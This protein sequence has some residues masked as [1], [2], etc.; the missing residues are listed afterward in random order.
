MYENK[1]KPIFVDVDENAATNL[2]TLAKIVSERAQGICH[3]GLSPAMSS[4]A[5][6][7]MYEAHEQ[8]HALLSRNSESK[9]INITHV[10]FLF[11]LLKLLWPAQKFLKLWPIGQF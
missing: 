9:K 2:Q 3:I 4:S 10:A 6:R 5:N 11:S 1:I 8:N 7:L